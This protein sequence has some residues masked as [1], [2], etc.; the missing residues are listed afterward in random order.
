MGIVVENN[1]EWEKY[2]RIITNKDEGDGY[3]TEIHKAV[4]TTET[5]VLRQ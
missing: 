5:E 2:M 1:K 4:N 3:E